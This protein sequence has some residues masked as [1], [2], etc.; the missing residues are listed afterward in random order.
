MAERLLR[1]TEIGEPEYKDAPLVGY[2]R[3]DLSRVIP[4]IC[5]KAQIMME[6]P[7][8]TELAKIKQ[9]HDVQYI[10]AM[11]VWF[12]CWKIRSGTW[13]SLPRCGFALN[14]ETIDTVDLCL[15]PTLA[16]MDL[17]LGELQALKV[18]TTLQCL[19]KIG[20]QKPAQGMISHCVKLIMRQLIVLDISF[21][22]QAVLGSA[23]L[24]QS[25][26]TSLEMDV[27]LAD[28]SSLPSSVGSTGDMHRCEKQDSEVDME[29]ATSEAGQ[30]T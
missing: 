29:I 11:F 5:F 14:P 21:S 6:P 10:A 9:D 16:K 4:W 28:I 3:P 22:S 13:P 30:S 26:S 2:T 7:W 8:Q 15:D 12:Q 17:L 27:S 19:A 1:S 24:T 25:R 18:L 23:V 20:P